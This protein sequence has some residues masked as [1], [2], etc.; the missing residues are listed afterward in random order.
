MLR[1]SHAIAWNEFDQ[2]TKRPIRIRT[3]MA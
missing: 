2:T 1:R 3:Q